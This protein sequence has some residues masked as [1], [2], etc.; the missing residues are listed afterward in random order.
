MCWA[1]SLWPISFLSIFSVSAVRPRLVQRP[2]FLQKVF[3]CLRVFLLLLMLSSFVQFL[4]FPFALRRFHSLCV[5]YRVLLYIPLAT[6]LWN[7]FSWSECVLWCLVSFCVAVSLALSGLRACACLPVRPS[8]L[9]QWPMAKCFYCF[10]YLF[11]L[12]SCVMFSF[13]PGYTDIPCYRTRLLIA[14][15]CQCSRPCNFLYECFFYLAVV[16]PFSS[17]SCCWAL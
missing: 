5:S 11:G 13:W 2:L 16:D 4:H 10:L 3:F 1:V 6:P 15:D 8:A 9:D 7:A 12:L 17:W 14:S